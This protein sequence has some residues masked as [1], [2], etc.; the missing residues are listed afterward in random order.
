MTPRRIGPRRSGSRGLRRR[1]LSPGPLVAIISIV[2]VALT[3]TAAWTA[4]HLDHVTE[5][6]L[7]DQQTK[8]AGAVLSTA[9]LLV[10]LPLVNALEV[11]SHGSGGQ[12][13]SVERLLSKSVG[14][15]QLFVTAS[16]W[17][18]QGRSVRVM[19]TVG[20]KPALPT[21]AP[22]TRALVERAFGKKTFTVAAVSVGSQRRIVYA[23]ADPASGYVVYA[24]RALPANRRAPV[25]SDSAFAELHYAIYLGP[26]TPANLS[27]TDVDPAH[28]PF[29]GT[30]SSVS[31]PFGDTEL[32]LVTSPRGHLGAALSQSLWL[33]LLLGGLLLT[34]AAVAVSRLLD[35]RRRAAEESASIAVGMSERLQRALLPLK[36]PQ[37]PQLEVAV[38]YVAGDTGVAIGGDW[39]SFVALDPDHYGFVVGDVSGRG[40]D[41][42]AVMARA[43]FTLRAYLLRGDS[44]DAALSASSHHFD[45]NA[46]D[47]IA[48]TIVGIGNWR[49]GEVS[50]ANAGHCRPLILGSQGATFVDVATGPPLGTGPFSYQA[51]SFVLSPGETVFC[52]T[53]GLVERRTE[54]LDTGMNRLAA[55]VAEVREDSVQDVVAHALAAMRSRHVEDDIAVLAFRWIGA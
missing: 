41:A 18:R 45:I 53:D 21:T 11:V 44:P 15:Q 16:I 49:T 1:H 3:G 31:L 39:Y 36:I 14:P 54:D 37:V 55:A 52:Y 25:A 43:R 22:S 47:H 17:H 42:V 51:T 6:R 4:Q 46:D 38:E 32:T 26:P 33:F 2:G 19:A 29:R 23:L 34:A 40:I 20:A 28:L 27:T 8:Q 30:T 5:Q 7:L 9:V 50:V 13:A 24:E 12:T 10:Q 35:Q 48:T